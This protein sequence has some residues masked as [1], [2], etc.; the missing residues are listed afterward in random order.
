[1]LH[2]NEELTSVR[3]KLPPNNLLSSCQKLNRNFFFWLNN[4]YLGYVEEENINK[5][6]TIG[7]IKKNTFQVGLQLHSVI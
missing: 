4:E 5:L 6:S 7:N 3:G 2:W 1:M